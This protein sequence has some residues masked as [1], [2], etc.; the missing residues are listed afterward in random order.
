MSC[1]SEKRWTNVEHQACRF[2]QSALHAEEP[3][4]AVDRPET[5]IISLCESDFEL[6]RWVCLCV[7]KGFAG[8]RKGPKK[9]HQALCRASH[10]VALL[11]C[12]KLFQRS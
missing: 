12:H 9:P 10:F 11:V 4:A 1:L 5:D 2:H 8:E 3:A 7:L 6:L